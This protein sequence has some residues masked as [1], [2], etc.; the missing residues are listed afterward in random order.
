MVEV[1][2]ERN[3]GGEGEKMQW[4][5]VGRYGF[6]RTMS[7]KEKR[8]NTS[9]GSHPLH[10]T[11]VLKGITSTPSKGVTCPNLLSHLLVARETLDE[12]DHNIN[13]GPLYSRLRKEDLFV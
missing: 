11:N 2:G 5:R 1:K 10:K 4:E 8:E 13:H 12:F 3:G 9:N 7:E 6:N